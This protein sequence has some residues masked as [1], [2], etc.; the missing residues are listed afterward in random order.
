MIFCSFWIFTNLLPQ[1]PQQL[2]ESPF[3]DSRNFRWDPKVSSII[4]KS[5]PISCNY[6]VNSDAVS[7]AT[8]L[9]DSN[10]GPGPVKFFSRLHQN[11]LSHSIR[12]VDEEVVLATLTETG[13][14]D[15]HKWI[16]VIFHPNLPL[17]LIYQYGIFR[18]MSIK[19]LFN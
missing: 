12:F 6:F 2:S 18:S 10:Y 9:F 8:G 13:S 5:C 14:M 16:N 11:L 4:S 7:G 15:R 3:L 19:V 17:I 1:S